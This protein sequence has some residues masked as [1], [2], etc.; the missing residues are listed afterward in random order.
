MPANDTNMADR[1]L[2]LLVEEVRKRTSLLT[3]ADRG[4]FVGSDTQ[5]VAPVTVGDNAYVATGSCVTRDVPAEALAIARCRQEN[6]EGY[7]ARLR[8]RL[9]RKKNP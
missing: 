2:A 9:R 3:G 7:A 8:A 5:M 6:K 1:A 4:A